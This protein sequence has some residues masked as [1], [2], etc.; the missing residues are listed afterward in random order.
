M[1]VPAGGSAQVVIFVP[2][3][4]RPQVHLA[5]NDPPA[6]I[7]LVSVTPQ[8][9]G[10]SVVVRAESGKAKPGLRGNLIVDAFTDRPPNA[11]NPNGARRR[12]FVSTLPAIPFEVISPIQAAQ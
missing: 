10:V 2:P 1:R 6:G 5:L 3:G 12:Q 7:F 9:S 4:L 8:N 11:A